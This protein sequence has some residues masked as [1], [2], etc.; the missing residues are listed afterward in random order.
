MA[1]VSSGDVFVALKA[2]WDAAVP[3][4]LAGFDGPH[5]SERLSSAAPQFPYVIFMPLDAPKH[6]KSNQSVYSNVLFRFYVRDRTP[7][8]VYQ[9]LAA[10]GSV[11]DDQAFEL[12]AEKGNVLRIERRN[13]GDVKETDGVHAGFLEYVAVRRAPR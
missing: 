8:L 3:G 11:F 6:R 7:E 12:A 2:L 4:A 13:E 10:I 9:H 1:T 5:H